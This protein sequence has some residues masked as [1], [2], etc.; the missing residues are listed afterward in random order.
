[1]RSKKFFN[2]EENFWKIEYNLKGIK[3]KSLKLCTASSETV[4]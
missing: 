2:F 3:F 1:M 4:K